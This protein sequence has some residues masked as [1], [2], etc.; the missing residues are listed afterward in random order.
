[1]K[2]AVKIS[3][4]IVGKELDKKAR[5]IIEDVADKYNLYFGHYSKVLVTK[6]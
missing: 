2:R 5:E 4:T 1:M 6:K 3:L